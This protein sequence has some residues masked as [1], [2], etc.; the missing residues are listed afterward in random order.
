VLNETFDGMKVFATIL[1]SEQ[2]HMD[3]IKTLLD[4]Y[5]LPDSTAGKDFGEFNDTHLQDLYDELVVNGTRSAEDAPRVGA[6][7]EEVDVV[8]LD[9]CIVRADN[10]DI[11]AAYEFFKSGSENHLRVFANQLYAISVEYGPVIL[12]CATHDATIMSAAEHGGG[13]PTSGT[14]AYGASL[15]ATLTHHLAAGIKVLVIGVIL[16]TYAVATRPRSRF[17]LN[18]GPHQ[19]HVRPF[20]PLICHVSPRIGVG[21]CPRKHVPRFETFC[22]TYTH[23]STSPGVTPPLAVLA[24]SE[25]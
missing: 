8:D 11:I 24:K 3:A 7:I 20:I 22:R 15:S 13:S 25:S 6:L 21:R 9:D 19:V 1:Q 5:G 4:K 12:H 18:R 2:T 16:V 10:S 23:D 17:S 14:P